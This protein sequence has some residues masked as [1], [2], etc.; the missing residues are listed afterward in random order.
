[1]DWLFALCGL[2]I[3]VM[4]TA[5]VLI[6]RHQAAQRAAQQNIASLSLQLQTLQQDAKAAQ[7]RLEA[8]MA[9]VD[10]LQL[11]QATLIQQ[12]S[13]FEGQNGELEKQIIS[14]K[15]AEAELKRQIGTLQETIN[16]LHADNA[17]L[18][19][20]VEKDNEWKKDVQGYLKQQLEASFRDN[21]KAVKDDAAQEYEA[22]QKVL[23]EKVKGI[24][25]PL[26]K[27]LLE[28]KKEVDE[29]DKDH[30]TGTRL[31][32]QELKRL[33]A[34]NTK[35]SSALTYNK[36]KGNW[37]EL[38]L[39]RLLEDSGM[40]EGKGYVKQ[41]T[42]G[43]GKRPDFR[44]VLPENRSI[45][46]DSKALGIDLN[47]PEND[48][49][50][51]TY[52]ARTQRYL[53]ALKAAIKGLST[54]EYQATYREAADFVV[55]YVPHE[56]MLSLA[57]EADP[58][59]FQWAYK[60]KVI[61][62]SPLNMMA[63]LQLVHRT[64]KMYKLSQDASEILKLGETLFAQ[65]VTVTNNMS[66]L[67][68]ALGTVNKRYQ[69]LWTSFAGDRQGLKKRIE[70]LAEYG[71]DKGNA[72]PDEVFIPEDLMVYE[73]AERHSADSAGRLLSNVPAVPEDALESV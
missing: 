68:K 27:A 29:I 52:K 70:Q 41:E 47:E 8:A 34:I 38:M 49:T 22:K 73:E 63:M 62:A 28:Y 4:V 6:S 67:G 55:L 14:L 72:M 25:E 30:H 17:A 13:K 35:L 1:M 45:F 50:E 11:E 60:Q 42:V 48:G 53:D 33:N 66:G 46:I 21:M 10:A 24:L 57:Y 20:E 26:S 36:G 15:A 2:L 31:I 56:G 3:G 39:E 23:D 19:T 40:V 69:S 59:I 16:K 7:D 61:L 64:W 43:D 58:A 12:K 71:A 18:Q 51:E 37:G 44:I 5:G 9:S 54:K 32:E 65:A